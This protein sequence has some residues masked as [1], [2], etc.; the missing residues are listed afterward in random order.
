IEANQPAL[1][2]T[3][4]DLKDILGKP[5]AEVYSWSYSPAVQSRVREAIDRA[6][7]GE[8]S[9][10]DV[11]LRV[12]DGRAIVIDFTL[13]PLRDE[14]GKIIFLVASGNVITERKRAEEA[15]QAAYA[16]LQTL[17][18]IS[19]G[20]LNTVDLDKTLELIL[21]KTVQ[22]G[23]FDLGFIRLLQ[24]DTNEME[25]VVSEGYAEPAHIRRSIPLAAPADAR[26]NIHRV[27]ETKKTVV[28]DALENHPGLGSLRREGART[29]VLVPILAQ[30]RALCIMLLG[31]RAPRTL[32]PNE[33][34][35]LE[36]IGNQ[37]GLAIEKAQLFKR[38]Q[39]HAAALERSNE[40]KSEFLGV[41]SH[42]LRTP[43]NIIMGY[44]AMLQQ[45]APEG[46]GDPALV[47]ALEKI[48]NPFKGVLGLIDAIMQ[49]TAIESETVD[50]NVQAVDLAALL[51]GLRSLYGS[52]RDKN[53]A[54]I[55]D[56]P[57]ALPGVF[58]DGE[59]LK[60]ILQNLI[61]NAIKFTES[62]T[63]TVSANLS[64]REA[65]GAKYE[66]R[67]A[68]SDAERVKS[69]VS[70]ITSEPPKPDTR[71]LTPDTK[72]PGEAYLVS[73]ISSGQTSNDP[74]D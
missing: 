71:H 28:F 16:E 34:R 32:R 72:D 1:A 35:L 57:A 68:A 69:Q 22:A 27:L 14:S 62:G 12:T 2:A 23:G 20:V 55:W 40:V 29:A 61:D 24:A 18:D 3:G 67:G 46:G 26:P 5:F 54:L 44:T 66:A 63:I 31:N 11:E 10:Y 9:R 7:R 64:S 70:S 41:M 51:A 65:A 13:Q 73:R 52:A 74:R 42:E 50:P 33:I 8:P 60:Q 36:A 6:A 58:T 4:L 17:H 30:E 43:L 37:A 39:T 56:F 38:A 45:Y 19:R 25:L 59:K 15:Q 47:Q 53:L 48:G 49:A 21:Q